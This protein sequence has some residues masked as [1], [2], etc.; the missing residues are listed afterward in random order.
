MCQ[1]SI[2]NIIC[3]YQTKNKELAAENLK[4]KFIIK[5]ILQIINQKNDFTLEIDKLDVDEDIILP[6]KK[7]N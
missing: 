1:I 2:N 5:S 3:E 7:Y 4:Y 6:L